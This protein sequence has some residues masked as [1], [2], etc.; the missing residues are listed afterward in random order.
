MN[1]ILKTLLRN[2]K[3]TAIVSST[4][5]SY[6]ELSCV[7]VAYIKDTKYCVARSFCTAMWASASPLGP[8]AQETLVRCQTLTDV[9]TIYEFADIISSRSLQKVTDVQLALLYSKL[10]EYA[11]GFVLSSVDMQG[12]T[13]AD[14]TFSFAPIP[15]IVVSV[16]DRN[17]ILGTF[18][19][20]THGQASV[21]LKVSERLQQIVDGYNLNTARPIYKELIECITMN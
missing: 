11:R 19:I 10:D 4:E 2:E 8:D 21:L 6:R 17:E 18:A 13:A 20:Q 12:A 9:A 14:I 16:V 7:D 3:V 1:Q 5:V 15:T